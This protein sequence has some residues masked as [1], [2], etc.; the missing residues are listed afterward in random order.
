MNTTRLPFALALLSSPAL[1]GALEVPGAYPTIQAAGDA[2]VAG[3]T[4]LVSPGTYHENVVIDVELEL[5]SVGGPGVTVIDGGGL[6]DAVSALQGCLGVEG[7]TLTG[8]GNGLRIF[9]TS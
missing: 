1:A 2:A 5:R 3:D 4:V 7:F 6:G 8:G 9:T